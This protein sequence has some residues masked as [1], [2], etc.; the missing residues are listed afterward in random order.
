MEQG[1][2]DVIRGGLA[3]ALVWGV[4]VAGEP[5]TR[6]AGEPVSVTTAPAGA[7]WIPAIPTDE[8]VRRVVRE[9]SHPS[10]SKRREAVRQLAA[11]GP[12]AFG[13][14]RRAAGGSDFEAALAARDLLAEL[15]SAILIGARIR[16]EVTPSSVA[17]NEPFTLTIVAHN[18]TPSSIRMPWPAPPE[19]ARDPEVAQVAAMMDVA[20]FLTIDGPEGR[21]E[22]LRVE[23]IARDPRVYEAVAQRAEGTSPTHRIEPGATARLELRAF[24]RGW[25]RFPMLR[26]GRYTIA[27]SYQPE[28]RDDS[29]VEAGFGRVASEPVTVEVRD[30]APVYVREA[31]GPMVLMLRPT[32]DGLEARMRNVWDLDQW[33]NLNLNGPLETH[34][35]LSW[36][37]LPVED[38]GDHEDEPDVLDREVDVTQPR[39]DPT[40]LRRLA[41]GESMVISQV[42]WQELRDQ[43]R[44]GPLHTRTR[45]NVL[46][47]YSSIAEPVHLRGYLR[48][49]NLPGEVPTHLFTGAVFARPFEFRPTEPEGTRPA[50]RTGD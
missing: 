4:G 34:A 39:F 50:R 31:I 27:L 41:P 10:S 7:D 24:N 5:A 9:L 17:W 30:D 46:V 18:P 47:R 22:A 6:P 33:V 26:G 29:W 23:A 11:W 35:N 45:V 28:W 1:W 40:R 32:E 2:A 12:A 44:N 25:A 15:E 21:I 14:L 8:E 20:D 19:T 36:Y 48:D 49:Q 37:M 42:R 43:V 3:A 13:E 16:L 38:E